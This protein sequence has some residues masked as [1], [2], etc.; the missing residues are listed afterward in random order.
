MQKGEQ[1]PEKQHIVDLVDECV[2]KIREHVD[3]VQIFVNKQLED[4]TSNTMFYE[5]GAGNLYARH[6]QVYEWLV[7]QRQFQKNYAM[8]RDEED[9][10]EDE[11]DET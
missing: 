5:R 9:F 4:G 7:I 10:E 6:G 8:R 1:S 2:A 11:D 3:S